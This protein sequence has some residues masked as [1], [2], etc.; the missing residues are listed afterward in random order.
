[1]PPKRLR[2][3][4]SVEV[5]NRLRVIV[6]LLPAAFLMLSLAEW[7]AVGFGPLLLLLMVLNIGV[8]AG[9][10]YLLLRGV[11]LGARGWVG[12]VYGAGNIAP[13]PSFSEQESL[14]IRGRFADA[15]QS[16][17]HHLV[18]RPGDHDARLALA[19]LYRRH[20]N[21]PAAAEKLYLGVRQGNPS[22]KQ[23]A[24]AANQLI[25]LYR[26]TGQRGR[27]MTEL[28]R[29]AERYAGS[30]AGREAR[31]ALTLMKE[32]ESGG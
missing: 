14:I 6:W 29:Y 5:T 1:M 23:E 15:E 22:A 8:I 10:G 7:K 12:M 17:L 4:D 31:T 30:R 9:L 28:A 18:D 2:D 27:L 25:D 24:T 13:A 3:V 11:E 19:D 20:L 32:D 16:F 26:A 21:N